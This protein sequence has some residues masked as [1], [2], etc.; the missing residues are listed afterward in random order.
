MFL[1]VDGKAGLILS[2]N[3]AVAAKVLIELASVVPKL[4][5][6]AM[7]RKVIPGQLYHSVGV[8]A[9]TPRSDFLGGQATTDFVP[10]F[11]DT[12][13]HAGILGQV[14]GHVKGLV[15]PS[16]YYRIKRF[17]GH[18]YLL[19]RHLISAISLP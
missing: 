5:E 15:P 14:H 8:A 18:R 10:S 6:I 1:T 11:K 19:L 16:N 4:R 17:I 9:K 7:E 3:S 13:T 12:D 2:K